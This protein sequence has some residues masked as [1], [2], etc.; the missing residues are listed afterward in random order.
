MKIAIN[1][2]IILINLIVPPTIIVVYFSLQIESSIS[3]EKR[4][5][6]SFKTYKD[7]IKKT[8]CKK[9]PFGTKSQ[10]K[11]GLNWVVETQSSS[12]LKRLFGGNAIR[13]TSLSY[14]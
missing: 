7:G 6:S 8:S 2:I 14:P 13:S 11:N 9:K 3:F 1:F 12:M 10:E 4:R 5:G